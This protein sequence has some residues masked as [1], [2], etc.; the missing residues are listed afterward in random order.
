MDVESV[1]YVE[2]SGSLFQKL[3]ITVFEIDETKEK[4][5]KFKAAICR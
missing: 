4:E 5:G 3:S 1:F 2:G